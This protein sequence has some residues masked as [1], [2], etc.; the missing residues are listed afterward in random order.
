[1]DGRSILLALI[2]VGFTLVNYAIV[3]DMIWGIFLGSK[4]K[5]T[6]QKIKD[7]QSFMQK[8]TQSYIKPLLT[9]YE[10][11]YAVWTGVK[12]ATF[13]LTVA[14]V[15]AFIVMIALK[16]PFWIVA[17]VC[18]VIALANVIL[19]IVMMNRTATSDNKTDR[20]G[21]PWEFEKPEHKKNGKRK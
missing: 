6:A 13:F 9:K 5:K 14:Q 4:S 1:M 15:I 7:E 19:F 17:I 3:R 20:K 16:V 11:E 10:K 8:W 18:G 12:R 2:P 21:S